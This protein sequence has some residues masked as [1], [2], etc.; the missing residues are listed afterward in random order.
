MRPEEGGILEQ[1]GGNVTDF[2]QAEFLALVQISRAGQGQHEQDRGPGPPQA[3][4]AIQSG[5]VPPLSSH[6]GLFW[7]PR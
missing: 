2:P 3:Q 5:M 1:L 6:A 7:L 4:A